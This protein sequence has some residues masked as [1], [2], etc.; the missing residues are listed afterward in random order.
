MRYYLKPVESRQRTAQSTPS[1]SATQTIVAVQSK[2][3]E[4][5]TTTS[6]RT[7]LTAPAS[8]SAS[9]S[10]IT[11]STTFSNTTTSVRTTSS[12]SS[13]TSSSTPTSS[14]FSLIN[15]AI[16]TSSFSFP[17]TS[18]APPAPTSSSSST[19]PPAPSSS[20]QPPAPKPSA[21][22]SSSSQAAP[23]PSPSSSQGPGSGSGSTSGGDIDQYLSAHNSVRAQHGASALSWSD[24]LAGK[25]QQW[26]NGCKFQHSGGSLGPFGENLA[27]GTGD[28][29][30]IAAAVKSWTDEVSEYDPNNPQASHFTQVVWK[31]SSQVGCALQLCDGI[32]AAS[33]G[34]AK[35]Y[36]CEYSSQGNVIG[37]F[38]QNVQV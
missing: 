14:S 9:S 7:T 31:G 22:S 20:S 25:A 2:Y 33:F 15:E 24:N 35:Y 5:P 36:V 38:A 13:P 8:S 18:T 1:S 4:A 19:P 23:S 12:S 21:S 27:A 11:N 16:A 6:V 28:S 26:A 3:T 37:Q 29:Y 30:D 17:P 34:K 32:F 10:V